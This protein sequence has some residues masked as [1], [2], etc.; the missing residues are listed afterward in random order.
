VG[1]V[2]GVGDLFDVIAGGD[3]ST[4]GIMRARF[5]SAKQLYAYQ[6]LPVIQQ[7]HG[8]NTPEKCQRLRPSHPARLGCSNC[9]ERACR[10]DNRLVKTMLTLLARML[11]R[12]LGGR[13]V[14]RNTNLTLADKAGE[15]VAA[16]G[17]CV[18]RWAAESRPSANDGRALA[19]IAAKAE[20]SKFE[21]CLPEEQLGELQMVRLFDVDGARAAVLHLGTSGR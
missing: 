15:S 6:F 11:E 5:D 12:E 4:D 19:S 1:D 3:D 8:T 20:L 17:D 9:P 7:A 18:R 2:V 10:A 21:P 16:V 13:V 14:A